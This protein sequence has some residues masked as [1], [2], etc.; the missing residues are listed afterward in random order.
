MQ[1]IDRPRFLIASGI[2]AVVIFLLDIWFHGTF[3]DNIY[4]GYPQRSASEI[5]A[6][7]PFLFATYVAQLM[8]FCFLF[9]R[10][11]PARGVASAVWW[12][13]WGGLFVVMPNMQFFVAIEGTSWT[14]LAMQVVEGMVLMVLTGV[15]FTLI[16]RPK[17]TADQSPT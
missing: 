12:G 4:A 11:Y 9:L 6:L 10:L 1:T 14:I 16:Y 2:V 8:L 13:I 7:F 5:M 3:A 15:I 17:I